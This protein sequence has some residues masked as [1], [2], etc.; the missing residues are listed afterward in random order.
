MVLM[1][2]LVVFLTS[3]SVSKEANTTL[4]V[5]ICCLIRNVLDL[6]F[7]SQ[8]LPLLLVLLSNSICIVTVSHVG[9]PIQNY[10]EDLPS[11]I[12]VLLARSFTNNRQKITS[13]TNKNITHL[14]QVNMHAVRQ[15]KQTR[16]Q[17]SVQIRRNRQLIKNITYSASLQ[18]RD[19]TDTDTVSR[20]K[21]ST[22]HNGN[23]VFTTAFQYI[24]N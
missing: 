4:A 21:L 11:A 20:F 6:D 18:R 22:S 16:A 14:R 3:S 7:I 19:H 15:Y 10:I 2:L 8:H 1:L 23:I 12:S 24:A 5:R 13:R 17:L 9:L